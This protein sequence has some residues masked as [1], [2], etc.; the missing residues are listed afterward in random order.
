MTKPTREELPHEQKQGPH[1]GCR[2]VYFGE[3]VEAE[4]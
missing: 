1:S 2:D 3:L 4:A